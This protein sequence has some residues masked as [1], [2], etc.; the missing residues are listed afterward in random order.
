[1]INQEEILILVEYKDMNKNLGFGGS[2]LLSVTE[3]VA[4]FGQFFPAV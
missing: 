2:K 1:M 3:F 4:H